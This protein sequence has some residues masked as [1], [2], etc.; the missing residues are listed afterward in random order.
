MSNVE[1]SYNASR[2]MREGSIEMLNSYGLK[3]PLRFV[4]PTD[5]FITESPVV[6][7]PGKQCDLLPYP[8]PT[9]VLR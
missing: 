1:R 2:R 3:R 6:T 4:A 9:Q 5:E 7:G 8:K